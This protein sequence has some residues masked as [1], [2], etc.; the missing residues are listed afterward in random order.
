MAFTASTI[1]EVV[2]LYLDEF[3]V[4]AG[5][6][7]ALRV[8]NG[9]SG[10]SASNPPTVVLSGGGGS[11]ADIRPTISGGQIIG[12]RFYRDPNLGPRRGQNYTSIPNFLF[13]GG[14]GSG[15]AATCDLGQNTSIL[16]KAAN[17]NSVLNFCVE[18]QINYIALYDCN[19]LNWGS[20]TSTN[21]SA[22][23]TNILAAFMR[24]ARASGITEIG[25]VRSASQAKTN[26]LVAYNNSRALASERFE[27]YNIE[28][29]WWNGDV[30]FAQYLSN[31]QYAHA[32]S[33]GSTYPMKV[34]IYIG[35]PDPGEM[36]QLLPYLERVL[37]HDYPPSKQPDY[38]YTRGRMI[39]IGNGC[40]AIGK[41]FVEIMPIFSAERLNSPWNAQYEFMGLYYTTQ[42]IYSAYYAWAVPTG[43]TTR[44]SYNHESNTNVRDRCKPVGHII[45]TQE[46]LRASNPAPVIP[47]GCTATITANGPTTFLSGGSGVTL[48]ASAG[49]S[50]LWFPSGQTTSSI[51]AL[52]TGT[53]YAQV[54][55]VGG[56]CTATT[57]SI[58]VVELNQTFSV[59]IIADGPLFF[60]SGNSV[61]LIATASTTGITYTWYP[62]LETT[63]GITV[64][65]TNYYYLIGDDGSGH[66]YSS[67]TIYIDAN[68]NSGGGSATE[69]TTEIVINSVL[70][71]TDAD[72][73]F[74]WIP[75]NVTLIDLNEDDYYVFVKIKSRNGKPTGIKFSPDGGIT[76]IPMTNITSTSFGYYRFGAFKLPVIQNL[77]DQVST[78]AFQA[79]NNA[80]MFETFIISANPGFVPGPYPNTTFV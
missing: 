73:V 21:L 69:E 16:G 28:N 10:Y 24:K 57:N 35:W 74:P 38:N 41:P 61:N 56:T 36:V 80:L 9:G 55:N 7:S 65:T 47:T 27:W 63:S 59:D 19:L 52:T 26:Q 5:Q 11:S 14:S 49:S 13:V 40:A 76:F 45:F 68:Y 30:S 58:N 51:T 1:P 34:E 6:L 53:Y 78:I 48:T 50:Y 22:P 31:I 4:P 77:Y 43:S 29:E 72:T 17:E 66:T 20:T 12:L 33:T 39:D 37:V 67:T 25:A 70:S 2:G 54:G 71:Y 60:T 62:N 75:F 8:T 3:I 44:G 15:A 64:N 23:G 42:T 32:Q 18:Q 46:L 79:V